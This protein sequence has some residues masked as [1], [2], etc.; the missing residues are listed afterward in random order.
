M[1]KKMTFEEANAKLEEIVKDME[2]K[3]LTLQ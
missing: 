1:N 2:N 3:G